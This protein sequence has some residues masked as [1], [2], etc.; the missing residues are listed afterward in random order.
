MSPSQTKTVSIDLVITS[1]LLSPSARL[2]T[3]YY[4]FHIINTYFHTNSIPISYNFIPISYQF[5]TNFIPISYQ[6]NTNF[7]PIPYQFHTIFSN[8][9]Q[10]FKIYLTAH[11]FFGK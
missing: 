9:F 3:F 1:Q 7:I 5:N 8:N 2:D 11:I 4:N 6:F 10:K